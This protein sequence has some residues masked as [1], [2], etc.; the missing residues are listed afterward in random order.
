MQR[1]DEGLLAQ[2]PGSLGGT[3][4]SPAEARTGIARLKAD[5]MARNGRLL[6]D[7]ESV[8]NDV[9]LVAL[10]LLVAES[11]PKIKEVMIR[12]IDNMLAVNPG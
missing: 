10:A 4:P 12:L 8:T 5:L 2:P 6:R 11:D 3:L 7:G 9:G 1:Y